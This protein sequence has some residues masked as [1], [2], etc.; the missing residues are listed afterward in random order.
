MERIQRC[1]LS[2][3][4]IW[5]AICRLQIMLLTLEDHDDPQRIFE[6]LNSTGLAL[7]E[8]D[9]VRNLVLMDL[10]AAEQ[11]HVYENYWNVISETRLQQLIRSCGG[12]W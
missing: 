11:E 12:T 7:S 6:S 4:Q 1:R 9:K 2:G 5:N 8:A 10:P 3:D